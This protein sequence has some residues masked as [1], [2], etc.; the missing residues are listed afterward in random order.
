MPSVSEGD[1]SGT[2][3]QR[4]KKDVKKRPVSDVPPGK[5]AVEG[6]PPPVSPAPND[7]I[8]AVVDRHFGTI[9]ITPSSRTMRFLLLFSCTF[10]PQG[11]LK[12]CGL[13]VA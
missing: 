13:Y 11:Y 3:K 10:I 8:G 4:A 5:K 1:L 9:E 7:V 12:K 2:A 6:L